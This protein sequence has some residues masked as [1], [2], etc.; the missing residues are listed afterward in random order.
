M[1]IT[2]WSFKEAGSP[3]AKEEMLVGF[4]QDR[5]VRVLVLPALFD[6]ANALRRFTLSV[7][8]SL[9]EAGI[10]TALPDLPGM[11]ESL[12]ALTGQTLSG[13][14]GHA[15]SLAQS[16]RATHALTLRGAALLAPE[17]L[18][19]WRY[20]PIDGSKLLA[21]LLRACVFE[22]R[23]AGRKETRSALLEAGRSDGLALGGWSIG[24][25]MIRELETASPNQDAAY[26][27]LE[28]SDFGAS[29]LWLRT[30]PSDDADQAMA[31]AQ[32]IAMSLNDTSQAR[33]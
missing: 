20:A 19:G 7:M 21:T 31:L 30:E 27:T 32:Q 6:E 15:Q 2:S 11:N 10:D 5:S 1:N 17:T 9:D 28:P 3:N 33:S 8:R 4:D 29:G 26:E 13:W 25:A 14:R 24:P 12:E 23:E 16:F 22:A 18:P